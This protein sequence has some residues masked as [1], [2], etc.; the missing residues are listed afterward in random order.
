LQ[1]AALAAGVPL[2]DIGTITRGAGARF[3]DQEGRAL[4]FSSPSFSHF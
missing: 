1:R 3:R 4:R 2:T